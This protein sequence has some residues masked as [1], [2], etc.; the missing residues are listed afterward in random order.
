MAR[1]KYEID[2]VKLPSLTKILDNCKIGGI[3]NLLYRANQAGLAGRVLKDIHEDNT[4]A[5]M[6]AHKII[7][8][9]LHNMEF[10]SED[11]SD[12]CIDRAEYC[13]IDFK[14]WKEENNIEIKN[15]QLSLV[16]ESLQ[17]GDTF[18]LYSSKEGNCLILVLLQN[19]IYPENLI[20]LAA[21]SKICYENDFNIASC[22]IIRINNPKTPEDPVLFDVQEYGN[23]SYPIEVFSEMVK[24][25][26]MQ[27][28]LKTLV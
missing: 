22:Y 11:Y 20:K 1:A 26:G 28:R 10:G 5:G 6:L 23:L 13:L 3:G 4:N 2:G 27:D 19:E 15:K 24:L 12:S 16:S 17:F 18:D 8:A 9:N 25:Y 14:H 7:S 21:R